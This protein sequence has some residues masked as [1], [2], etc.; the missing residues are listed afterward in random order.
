M[1]NQILKNQSINRYERKWI[2]YNTN[3]TTFLVTLY[4]SNFLFTESFESRNV[5]S[6]YFDDNNFSSIAENFY[7]LNYKRKYRI[8]WYGDSKVINNPQFEIKTKKGSV[9]EKKTFFI[10][11]QKS[12]KFNLENIENLKNIF[13]KLPY[14]KLNIKKNLFPI[15]STHYRRKYFVSANQFI[16]ATFDDNL[17]SHQIYGFQNLSFK[18]NLHNSIFEMKYDTKFDD[19]VAK[20]L[21]NISLRISKNSKY[22]SAAIDKPGSFS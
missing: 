19:Y 13:S 11:D 15:L 18:K 14:F 5:N 16:R 1:N 2:V 17:K 10:G 21:K 7:G 4:R 8:R 20:N 9:T 3:T 12:F 22:I 6:I